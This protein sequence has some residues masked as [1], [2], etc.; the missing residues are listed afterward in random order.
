MFFIETQNK[1]ECLI[2]AIVRITELG[3]KPNTNVSKLGM[4]KM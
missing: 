1:T 4:T 2:V 3:R